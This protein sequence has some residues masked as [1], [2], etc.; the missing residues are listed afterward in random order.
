MVYIGGNRFDENFHRAGIFGIIAPLAGCDQIRGVIRST[1]AAAY[2]MVEAKAG[3]VLDTVAAIS[4]GQTIANVNCEALVLRNPVH[5]VAISVFLVVHC[6]GNL[7]RVSG[8]T[9]EKSEINET[10]LTCQM[11]L[12]GSHAGGLLVPNYQRN[13][14]GNS[15]AMLGSDL[16]DDV[17]VGG[18][19]S[20]RF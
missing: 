2:D 3:T 4:A 6:K 13:H 1:I 10:F 9:S 15:L 7:A 12:R 20:V 5:P 11:G 18:F 16:G 14:I 8:R 19:D 17:V